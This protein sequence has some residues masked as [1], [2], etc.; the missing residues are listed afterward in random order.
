MESQRCAWSE[1][2]SCIR[3]S[4]RTGLPDDQ[5]KLVVE[6][7][8]RYFARCLLDDLCD[9]RVETADPS[10]HARRRLLHEAERV[11]D[12]KRHLLPGAEREIADGAFGLRA[13]I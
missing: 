4:A 10:I 13:P 9:P 6:V 12:F 1:S 3:L 2:R 7:P 11:Y 5:R 8:A